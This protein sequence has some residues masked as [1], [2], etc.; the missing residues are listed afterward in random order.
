VL[1]PRLA[2]AGKE[3]YMPAKTE[4][5]RKFMGAEL[6]RKREGKK[7]QTGM[8]EKQLEDFASKSDDQRKKD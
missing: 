5:Q 6:Q 8:S 4:K 1:R 2:A 7:T 3:A